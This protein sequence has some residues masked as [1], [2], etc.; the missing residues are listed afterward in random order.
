[1]TFAEALA[2]SRGSMINARRMYIKSRRWTAEDW[3]RAW[4]AGALA[5][6]VEA[7]ARG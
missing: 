7:A 4:Q 1:M 6:E 5:T 3:Y 2:A